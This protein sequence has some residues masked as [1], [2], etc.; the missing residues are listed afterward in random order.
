MV[1]GWSGGLGRAEMGK[2]GGPLRMSAKKT[3]SFLAYFVVWLDKDEAAEV[4]A[5]AADQ[6]DYSAFEWT[7]SSFSV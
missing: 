6:T 1:K 3:C 2:W 5:A 7:V 4:A